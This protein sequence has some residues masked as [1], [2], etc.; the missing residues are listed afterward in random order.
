[1]TSLGSENW[2]DGMRA[3]ERHCPKCARQLL[4]AK[5][6]GVARQG[7]QPLAEAASGDDID[8]AAGVAGDQR[9]YRLAAIAAVG[10]ADTHACDAGG[11]EQA[12]QGSEA[13]RGLWR[14]G[15][16]LH[17]GAAGSAR[18]SHRLDRAPHIRFQSRV[19]RGDLGDKVRPG[20][21][22]G[23]IL[24]AVG[25]NAARAGEIQNKCSSGAI[26]R[27]R[28]KA[29]RREMRDRFMLKAISAG[30]RDLRGRRAT[31]RHKRRQR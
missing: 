15:H 12:G 29:T 11:E 26:S 20:D 1:M 2:F 10:V 6:D 28:A 17:T 31:D 8:D 5:D 7:P 4:A 18:G 24:A 9:F 25:C 21:R 30:E 22:S 23:R 3:A 16:P 14:I 19:H 27:R 13:A